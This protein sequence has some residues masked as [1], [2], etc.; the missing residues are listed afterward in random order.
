MTHTHTSLSRITI[1]RKKVNTLCRLTTWVTL[2]KI[3]QQIPFQHVIW[4]QDEQGIG[5]E[6]AK[7]RIGGEDRDEI[8]I[9]LENGEKWEQEAGFVPQKAGEKQKVELVLY[10]DGDP[11]FEEPPYL[12]IDVEAP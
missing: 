9:E 6:K 4:G 3:F 7:V 2:G 8:N 12:W 10:K 11:F 5:L 1:S